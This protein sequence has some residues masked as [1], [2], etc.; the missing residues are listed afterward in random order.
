[1]A[2]K[3]DNETP[4]KK[5]EGIVGLI[6]ALAVVSTVAVGAGWYVGSNLMGGKQ[7]KMATA[8]AAADMKIDD[9]TAAKDDEH[10]DEPASDVVKLNPIVTN[11]SNYD[12]TWL[13]LELA[14]IFQPGQG[15]ASEAENLRV[16][17]DLANFIQTVK[18]PQISGPSGLLH[19]R[20][21]L[22]DRVRIATKGRVKEILI[23]SMVAE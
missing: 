2:G 21:D 18:L 8:E 13:R 6:A 9:Q 11:L 22:T 5:G 14:L 16:Q 20:E 3:T 4:P 1:M 19:L 10:G 17:S 15:F 12:D 7:A 23:L